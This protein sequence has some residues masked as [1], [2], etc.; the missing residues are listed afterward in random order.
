MLSARRAAAACLILAAGLLALPAT[1]HAAKDSDNWSVAPSSGGGTRPAD[2]D[3]PYF[4]LEGAPGVVLQDTVAVTNPGDKPLTV[5]LRGTDADN[6][7]DGSASVRAKEKSAD[8]GTWLRLKKERITVPPRTRA[9]VPFTAAV[10]GGAQPGDHPAA[11]IASSGGR[12]VGVWVHLTVSGPT[13]SALTVEK[14]RIDG[15][16]G[17][18]SYDVVNRGNTTLSPK[19]AVRAE[20][21]FGEV[22]RRAP[23]SLQ[24]ELLP[25]RKVSLTE[26]WPDAP[27][28]DSVDVTLTV[29]AGGGARDEAR[30]TASF[31]PWGPVGGAGGGLVV[32]GAA[33]WSVRRRR[34]GSGADEPETGQEAPGERQLVTVSMSARTV[35]A[36]TGEE[37]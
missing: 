6:A 2:G 29:T 33:L 19:L 5:E 16:A 32:V 8:S 20:G 17:R 10:P 37:Q 27:T 15:A 24:V 22:L 28:L 26:P 23:R 1:A 31:V 21:L 30:A 36:R 13:L 25:G 34:R 35:S 12:N 3:R 11:I 4:Y 18:I 7:P 9:E 14:V